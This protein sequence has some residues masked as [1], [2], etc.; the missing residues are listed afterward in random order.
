MS[1]FSAHR[2]RV[3]KVLLMVAVFV[4]LK[5]GQASRSL[6][7][8]TQEDWRENAVTLEGTWE[9]Q[10]SGGG[11]QCSFHKAGSPFINYFPQG[12]LCLLLLFLERSGSGECII[13][14]ITII[15]TIIIFFRNSGFPIQG[16][17]FIFL[18]PL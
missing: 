10:A 18:P 2:W 17:K 3:G 4:I 1:G 14:I 15:S 12:D 9:S 7:L 6:S 8:Q 16:V 5:V 11:G 13:I